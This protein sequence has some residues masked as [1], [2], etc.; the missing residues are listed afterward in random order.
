MRRLVYTRWKEHL[1]ALAHTFAHTFFKTLD[2]DDPPD[3]S[4]SSGLI[5]FYVF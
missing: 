5:I 4:L 1:N 3:K 2:S